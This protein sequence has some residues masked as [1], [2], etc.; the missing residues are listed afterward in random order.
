MK[1]LIPTAGLIL[2]ALVFSGCSTDF[3][4]NNENTALIEQ[5]QGKWK[6]TE[7]YSDDQPVNT[8]I[9]NGY[10]I[11]F[12]DDKTFIS[13]EENGYTGGTYTILN[14]QEN[15]IRLIYSKNWSSKL[16]YK[17]INQL[18]D[19]K[20]YVN[21]STQEPIPADEISFAGYILTRVP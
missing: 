21:A 14:T 9:G 20:M 10:E 11:E 15:N 18:T 3:A 13:N 2:I 8:P 16:V 6:L 19:D 1:K 12:K 4:D 7:S 17:H 5:I